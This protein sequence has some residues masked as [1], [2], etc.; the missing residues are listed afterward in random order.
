MFLHTKN[1]LSKQREGPV[2]LN[3]HKESL[4][5]SCYITLYHIC[6]ITLKEKRLDIANVYTSMSYGKFALQE[7][8]YV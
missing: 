1:P 3:S 8:S 4:Q 5:N 2:A 7:K 6:P